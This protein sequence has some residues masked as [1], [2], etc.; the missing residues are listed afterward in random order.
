MP[1]AVKKGFLV[2]ALLL[3]FGCVAAPDSPGRK[4]VSGNWYGTI[5]LPEQALHIQVVLQQSAGSWMGRIDI[6]QQ[7]LTGYPLANVVVE[8]ARVRFS[9]PGIAGDPVFDGSL[10][11]GRIHGE[12]RQGSHRN[13]F[14]LGREPLEIPGM[15]S[16]AKAA[17]IID[18]HLAAYNAHDLEAFLA[19][20][21]PDVEAY[22]FPNSLDKS[23]V[24]ALRKSF[25]ETF[26]KAPHERVITRIISGNHVI[27]EVEVKFQVNGQA[28]T[29]R[30]TVIYTLED[31]LIRR[32]TFL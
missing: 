13:E 7:G 16:A 25:T 5:T 3:L 18:G 1:D 15:I 31:G 6:P 9:L 22:N 2:V 24:A 17:H 14:Y 29:D 26:K 28:F 27:D 11:D 8:D 19:F 10:I 23:G 30:S 12:F 21:H 32:M 20:F 4:D